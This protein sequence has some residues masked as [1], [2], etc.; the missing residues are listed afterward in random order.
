MKILGKNA[1]IEQFLADGINY[2]FGNPGTTE[3]GFLD[4][5][6]DY[7]QFKYILTLHESVAVGIADGYARKTG[8][9]AVVQLHSGVGLGNGIGMLYQAN[10][11]H[12]P[13]VVIAGEAGIKYEAMDAQMAA[14]LVDMAKPVT[15]WAYKVT[16]R[17]SLLRIL[18]RA[19][20]ISITPPTGP[21]FVSLPMD[22]LE[23]EFEDEII[24]STIINTDT[25]PDDET[26][27][28]ISGFLTDAN[29]P[30]FIVGDGISASNAQEELNDF[31]NFLGAE[32]WGADYS[33]VNIKT[34]NSLYMGNLGHMFGDVSH[35][36]IKNADLILIC[37]SYVFPEVFPLLKDAF[38]KGTKIIHIDKNSYEIAKNFP[39]DM[40]LV[41]DPKLTLKKLFDTLT[42]KMP[43]EKKLKA[44]ER[45]E[46]ILLA[47]EQKLRN[48]IE[49]DNSRSKEKLHQAHFMSE[50][51]KQ[52]PENAIIFDEA[53]TCSQDLTRYIHPD[54]PG[55]Y[56]L[57]RG[58]SLG[59][60]IPGAIG[61]KLAAEDKTVIGFSGDGG[62]L[63]TIQALWSAVHHKI[64]AKFV[65]C[66]NRSYKLLKLNIDE[67]WKENKILSHEYPELFDLKNPNIRFDLLA[68]SMGVQAEKVEKYDEIEP[69]I[70]KMLNTDVPFLIE[71]VIN[72]EGE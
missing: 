10:R 26:I 50:L 13:L 20:K 17:A 18:R 23:Q 46:Q 34:S 64:N 1:I 59:V 52:L 16:D 53:L 4:A 28:L 39:V 68:Q 72:D 36:I 35:S 69:A 66:N 48:E 30:I 44:K 55:S 27:D 56:F 7:P 60:G 25:C 61:I 6:K 40:G 57:T 24:L 12:T 29:K 70:K 67:Y 65:I 37:G 62:S 47:K 45:K 54:V 49:K 22:I 63:Y 9:P 41:A 19:I 14:N 51:A 71:F 2:M 15:K 31:A 32:V 33:E 21:V 8:K 11:G 43:E 58:G 3:E 5:L 42:R 38:S